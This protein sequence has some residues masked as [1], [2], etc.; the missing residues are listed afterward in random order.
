[1]SQRLSQ[2][3]TAMST[4]DPSGGGPVRKERGKCIS[5]LCMSWKFFTCVFS[6]V[7]LIALVVSYCILGAYTFQKLESENELQV[8]RGDGIRSVH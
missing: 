8:R 4:Y 7:M 2:R 5:C 6:H 1:M 3:H